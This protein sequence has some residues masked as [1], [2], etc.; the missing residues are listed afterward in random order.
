MALDPY[1]PCTCGSGKKFKWCCQPIFVA[2]N[3]A[4]EQEAAGQHDAALRILDQVVKEH[5][6]NPE[7][8]GQKARLLYSQGKL[9]EAENAL[10]RAFDL[11]PNYPAGL[12]LRASFRFQEGEVAGALL[13][14]RRAAEA[15]DPEARSYLA[16]VYYLIF[17]SEMRLNRPVAAHAALR[18]VTRFAPGEEELRKSYDAIFGPEGRLPAAARRAY[19]FRSPPHPGPPP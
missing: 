5:E 11:N 14:A 19:T 13:L 17:E 7:A 10:Q 1:E 8:W 15:Y 4:W 9:E 12:L 16:E 6:G 18:L 3:R 2:I